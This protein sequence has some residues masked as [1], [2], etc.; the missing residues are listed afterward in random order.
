MEQCH[1]FDLTLM[2]G[3]GSLSIAGVK[4]VAVL[5]NLLFL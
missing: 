3:G 4:N 2:K 5:D 1:T